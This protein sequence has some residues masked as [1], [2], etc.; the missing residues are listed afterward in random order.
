MMW[1]I[2]GLAC[3]PG[4]LASAAAAQTVPAT[5][6][7]PVT[8]PKVA[9]DPFAQALAARSVAD[10]A[11]RQHD[12]V[13]MITAARMLQEIPFSD[14]A[15]DDA[16][17]SPAGLFAEAKLLA[18]GD[19]MLLMQITV[20]QSTGNRGVMESAFGKGLVRR[21]QTVDPLGKYQFDV[22]A[23]G[24]T[25]L[26]LGAIGDVGTALMMRMQ[27]ASGKTVCI[28]DHGDYGPVCEIVPK[29]STRYRVNIVNKS[30]VKSRAV[31]LSN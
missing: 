28:D 31:I 25:P 14:A 26:R 11:R 9:P 13:A 3:A 8:A 1:K 18:K 21:M 19:A 12:P 2:L 20:A 24:G 16:A 22:Q 30:A 10:F 7:A 5:G 27:D 15:E 17:F 6:G 23:S 4:M 29:A